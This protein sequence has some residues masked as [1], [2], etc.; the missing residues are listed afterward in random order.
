MTHIVPLW[1]Q[2]RHN[3]FLSFHLQLANFSAFPVDAPVVPIGSSRVRLVFHSVNT[4]EQVE[5][6]TKCMGEWAQEMVDI[7]ESG[8][9]GTK[10]PSAAY[11]AYATAASQVQAN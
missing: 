5:A 2:K 8:K 10:L 1:T 9:A 6:L 7:Q 4:E 11:Q 3:F